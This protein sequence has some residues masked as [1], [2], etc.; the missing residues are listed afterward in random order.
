MKNRPIYISGQITS[1]DPVIQK[2]NIVRFFEVEK[3]LK[4]RG[5]PIFNP[6]RTEFENPDMTEYN[7]FMAL[8]LIYIIEKKPSM[9]MLKGWKFSKGALLEHEVA[10]QLNLPIEYEPL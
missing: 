3:E 6:A 2:L 5:L 10:V 4:S 9:Y 8:D 1:T 7:Q